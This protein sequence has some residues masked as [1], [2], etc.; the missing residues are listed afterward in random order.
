MLALRTTYGDLV[1]KLPAPGKVFDPV[2]LEA[3]VEPLH[4]R[5][6]KNRG[7]VRTPIPL[8]AGESGATQGAEWSKED[9]RGLEAW[10]VTEW[11]GGGYYIITVSDSTAPTPQ[12]MEWEIYYHP[13]EYPEKTPPTLM[14]ALSER[15]IP[16]PQQV[17]PMVAFPS[18]FPNGFPSG[19]AQGI[20]MPTQQ[21]YVTPLH[22]RVD[23]GYRDFYAAQTGAQAD[24]ERRR[25]EERIRELEAQAARAR[26]A[27]LAAQHRQDLERAEA[28]MRAEQQA[29]NDRFSKLEQ[30]IAALAQ[31]QARPANDAAVQ[32]LQEQNRIL[33]AQAEAERRER[34][35]ERR[36]RELRDQ[37]QRQA[38]ENRRQIELLTAQLN[39]NQNKGLDPLIM[40][41]QENARQQIEAVR[42]QMSQMTGFM[43]N[44]RDILAM[45]KESSNGL[46]QATRSIT[47]TYQSIME[48]QQK[49]VEQ[50][51][52]L[53]SPGGS[54]TIALV[55][56]G[57]ERAS[58]FAERFIGGKTREAV[59]AQQAQAQMAAAQA[60]MAQAEAQAL[61]ARAA[62]MR[63]GQPQGTAP[64]NGAPANAVRPPVAAQPVPVQPIAPVAGP[65]GETREWQTSADPKAQ[66]TNGAPAA[67][68]PSARDGWGVAPVPPIGP[69]VKVRRHLGRTD[70]EWFGPILPRVVQLRE[71]VARF[72]ESIAQTP[73]RLKDDGHVD[74][75]EP[76][77]A[78]GLILQASMLVMQQQIPIAAMIDLLGQGRIADFM[79]TLLPDAPQPYRD[80]VAQMVLHELQG[81]GEDDDDDDE[82]DPED[83]E[84]ETE[85]GG[86]AKRQA[87]PIALVPAASAPRPR[88]QS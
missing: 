79:D 42:Q 26:E 46:D 43:M 71:G 69:E 78:A 36:D 9:V 54:E 18:A 55:K 63:Q 25:Y 20:Q 85:E 14:A 5:V 35:A 33:A 8:P 80:E 88:A 76:D 62:M 74:G 16:Q 17:R 83:P 7:K 38:E 41:L 61:T 51:L 47:S 81:G 65:Q 28:R 77:E 12:K 68:A 52:Q 82:D 30:M 75:V 29:Q 37:M 6:E 64:T 72:M 4:V 86:Q 45:A 73:P 60:Q 70:E 11:S 50:V 21:A 15:P 48:M 22:Q 56:E 34:E 39:G 57:L 2:K 66:P 87:P 19:V 84:D 13:N 10:L 24:A 3:M 32:Q 27:E 1:S 58:S 53:N 44:P 59:T 23:G 67:T 40:M 49:A 31:A